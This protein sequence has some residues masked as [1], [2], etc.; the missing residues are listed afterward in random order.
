MKKPWKI[1]V[2]A[3]TLLPYLSMALSFVSFARWMVTRNLSE[4]DYYYLEWE[5]TTLW[6]VV[7]YAFYLVHIFAKSPLTKQLR[8]VWAVL[9]VLFNMFIMPVYWFLY[10]WPDK[11]ATAKMN[12]PLP[13]GNIGR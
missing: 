2:L 4:F 12:L 11:P 10:I 3:V 13:S 6:L 8:V 5:L 9:I 1:F 7:M